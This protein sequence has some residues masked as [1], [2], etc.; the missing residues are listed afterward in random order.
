M[1]AAIVAALVFGG[2]G[3]AIGDS[4]GDSD[5]RNASNDFPG[6]VNG[7]G[8]F[9]NGQ[10]P[11]GQR[12]P[13]PNG[14]GAN[15]NGGNGNGGGSQT[16]GDTA[17][18]GVA[19]ENADGGAGITQV[20]AGSPAADAGLKTGDV[21]TAV[22]GTNVTT[23]AALATTIGEHESGDEITVTYTRDGKS[24]TAKVTLGSRSSTQSS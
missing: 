23:A 18:L 2:I 4:S 7:D 15:G 12:L 5:S 1:A 21:V 22:D 16:S 20:Q 3:Y 10:L 14:N 9:A 17:F 13:N 8:P 24:A 6:A 11:N 19:L